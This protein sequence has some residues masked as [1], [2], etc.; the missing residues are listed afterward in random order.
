MRS[1]INPKLFIKIL[2]FIFLPFSL[3]RGNTELP[4]RS[5]NAFSWKNT[6]ISLNFEFGK[7]FAETGK[8]VVKENSTESAVLKE[9]THINYSLDILLGYDFQI[10]EK[11]KLGLGTGIGYSFPRLLELTDVGITFKETYIKIPLTIHMLETYNTSFYLAQSMILG[12]EFNV[13]LGS[14]YKQSGH[15]PKLHASMR[16]N[17][18]MQKSI[19]N[20]SRLSGRILLGTRFDFPKGIYVGT[21]IGIPIEIFK[22][23]F[24]H[25]N[26]NP[27]QLNSYFVDLMRYASTSCLTFDIGINIVECF[28]SK[29]ELKDTVSNKV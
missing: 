28:F 15:Y 24:G 21:K 6:R 13:I 25:F 12:Y 1:S 9:S 18:D 29:Q 26:E 22:F 27:T 14:E 23:M 8:L 19:P 3:V 10:S 4:N 5:N 2:L 16:G 11:R 20:F 7:P 17:K